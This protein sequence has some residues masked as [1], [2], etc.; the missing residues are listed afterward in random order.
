MTSYAVKQYCRFVRETQGFKIYAFCFYID[1]ANPELN[2]VSAVE[3]TLHPSFPD[4]VRSS[5]DKNHAFAL[6]SEAGE[7]FTTHVRIFTKSRSGSTSRERTVSSIF[8]LRGC[9][10]SSTLSIRPF[11]P[12]LSRR[13]RSLRSMAWCAGGRAI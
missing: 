5:N 11:S 9:R 8:L 7:S 3:Y 4:P 2:D 10:P 13:V 6:Q 12:E 1:A